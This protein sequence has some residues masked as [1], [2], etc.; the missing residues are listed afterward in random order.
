MNDICGINWITPRF[1]GQRPTKRSAYQIPQRAE[2]PQI[3]SVGQCPTKRNAYY[4]PKLLRGVITISPFQGLEWCTRSFHRALPYA[5]DY[6]L[7]AHPTK[8][9]NQNSQ[10]KKIKK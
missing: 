8:F 10:Y 4:K 6:G 2:S 9:K 3:N 7:S 1:I 5:I